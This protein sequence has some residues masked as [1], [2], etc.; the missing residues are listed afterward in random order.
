MS[1]RILPAAACIAAFS[2]TA[3]LDDSGSPDRPA[4]DPLEQLAYTVSGDRLIVQHSGDAVLQCWGDSAHTEK[5]EAKFDTVRFSLSGNTL[6]FFPAPD[7]FSSAVVQYKDTLIRQGQ[8]EGLEGGWWEI[9]GHGYEA[10]SGELPGAQKDELDS[11]MAWSRARAPL[12]QAYT[13]FK[14]GIVTVFGD[15]A[16]ADL[17]ILD[18]NQGEYP[19][20]TPDSSLYAMDL[21]RVEKHIVELKGEKTGETVRI[22]LQN[23]GDRHYE[24]SNAAHAPYWYRAKP[25]S[26]PNEYKPAWYQAFLEANRKAGTQPEPK[27][28]AA[29]IPRGPAPT[30]QIPVF[31]GRRK[32]S[33]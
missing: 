10:V 32:A 3:C 28:S 18:W 6:V 7:T 5:P 8:G 23:N 27:L 1:Y 30:L 22:T 21:K 9:A 15:A 4:G 20:A 12:S 31:S 16:T 19:R 26:C 24:S 14:N 25:T 17:F 33:L 11:E 2:L 29:G 13:E